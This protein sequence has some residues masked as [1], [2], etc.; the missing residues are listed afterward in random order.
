MGIANYSNTR[1]GKAITA[2][3][4][5]LNR[6]VHLHGPELFLLDPFMYTAPPVLQLIRLPNSLTLAL[7]GSMNSDGLV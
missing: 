4:A 6:T 5:L 2:Y 1:L 7:E 3:I